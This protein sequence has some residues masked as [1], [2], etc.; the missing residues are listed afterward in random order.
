MTVPGRIPRLS[1][2]GIG[3]IFGN[4]ASIAGFLLYL[5]DRT[6]SLPGKSGLVGLNII[7]HLTILTAIAYGILWSLAEM[8]FGWEFGAGAKETFPAGVSAVVLS[9]AMTLPLTL[10]PYLYQKL[11][12]TVVLQPLHWRGAFFVLSLGAAGHLLM[13]GTKVH[14][15][16]GLRYKILPAGEHPPLGKALCL[17][18]LYSAVYVGLIVVPYR[19]IV[20]PAGPL[21][22]LVL[23]RTV[24]PALVFFFGMV[25]FIA[26]RYPA[27]L[28]DPAWIQVRGV[29]SGLIMMLSFCGGMF[30]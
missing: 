7:L 12:R 24:L 20:D 28:R 2:A 21:L 6:S 16:N 17:E 25:V 27:S 5:A 19:L 9:L 23:G 29:L 11:T 18:A 4:F 8:A 1:G 15:P 13:Y 3:S 22:E 10:V 26:V 30:L 14:R